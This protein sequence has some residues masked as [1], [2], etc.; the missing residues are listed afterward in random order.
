[1]LLCAQIY[2]EKNSMVKSEAV[3]RQASQVIPGGVSANIKYFPPFPI[4]MKKGYG[5]KLVDMDDNEYIDYSLCYGAL[6]TG[7]GHKRIMQAT[8]DFLHQSGTA[9]FGTPHELEAVMAEKLAQLYPA[10][11][12][13]RFTNSGSEAIQLAIRLA[14]AYTGKE[15]IGKFE[16]H[17]HGGLNHMLVS[18]NPDHEE[19][20]DAHR[21][22]SI[23]ES[24]GI[25]KHELDQTLVLPFNDLESVETILREHKDDLA[26]VILEPVQGGFIPATPAFMTGLRKLTEELNI[27]LIFDEVKT[28]FRVHL[29]GA[30]RVFHV[31]PDITT[32]GKVLGGGYPIGAVG[33]KKD[34]M[35]LSAPNEE[36]DVFATG[37]K[38][39]KKDEVVFH[40][41]TYNGH[42]IALA[43]GLETIHMLEE[44]GVMND[45]ARQT[46]KLRDQLE[47]L[48]ATYD[49]PMQTIGMGSIFNIVLTD[50]PIHNYRDMWQSN[51]ALRQKIDQALLQLGIFSKPLNR[52]SMS[53]AHSEA[54]I[55]RTVAAHEKALQRVKG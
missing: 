4:V 18:I 12:M 53:L 33:G 34:I 17:Y 1:M 7:H 26:A 52:Y 20:G 38:S 22:H 37:S 41:G 47:K 14:I 13:V 42:P 46:N 55:N 28:G 36:S 21:P 39:R 9:I 3:Y 30:Q 19:A 45:I 15:K 23:P 11:D 40:S 6:V 43:A 32:L 50:K 8:A 27:V 29:G 31:K 5:S 35:M 16:G 51:T 54:D 48:Y 10:I 49:V 24:K 44:D 25:P 2:F